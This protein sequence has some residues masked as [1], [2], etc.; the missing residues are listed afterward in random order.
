MITLSGLE[1]TG[2]IVGSFII[3]GMVG[4]TLLACLMA[5]EDNNDDDNK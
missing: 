2:I 3:G 4:I 1:L 5:S